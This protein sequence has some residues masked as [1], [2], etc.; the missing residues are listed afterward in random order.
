MKYKPIVTSVRMS[1]YGY[2]V[3]D[4]SIAPAVTCSV[5]IARIGISPDDASQ[6]A[7]ARLP[8]TDRSIPPWAISSSVSSLS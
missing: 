8:G 1:D 4:V 6:L 5:M 2:W 3:V 7:F